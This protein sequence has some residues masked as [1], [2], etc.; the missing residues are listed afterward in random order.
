MNAPTAICCFFLVASINPAIGQPVEAWGEELGRKYAELGS[1]RATYRAVSPTA[2]EPLEGLLIE[3]R[4]T[5]ACLVRL[6]SESGQ[7][8]AVWWMPQGG[9]EKGGTYAKFGDSTFKVRGLAELVRRHQ[10]L[11]SPGEREHPPAGTPNL[12]PSIQLGVET[13]SAFLSPK[14]PGLSPA[15]SGAPPSRVEELRERQDSIELILDDGSWI[16]LD[17]GTGLLAGQGYPE[18]E[19]ER[20][21]TLESVEPLQGR[22]AFLREIP[23]IDPTKLKE[24]SP[25]ALQLANVLHSALFHQF[26]NQTHPE[27]G[28]K[29]EELV[30]SNASGLKAYW[31]AAWGHG[32]PPGFPDHVV[33]ML[34]DL[35]GQKKQFHRDWAAAKEARPDIMKDVS[36]F[37]YF[38]LRRMK[39]RDELRLKIEAESTKQPALA[40][41]Q[42]LLDGE[43]SK[44]AAGQAARG[45]ELA[46][47]MVQSQ[48][49][50]MI[51]A[52]LPKIPEEA[53]N[54]P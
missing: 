51:N 31:L 48:R 24:A 12:A 19:G 42:L 28:Q 44:L 15:F 32:V 33:R 5:G 17:R 53:L 34:R 47:L 6:Q 14:M 50:A 54:S 16:R 29:P 11:I 2:E 39:L 23:K 4:E 7:G 20:T 21:L 43:L 18:D 13:I 52:I 27:R 22:N 25:E 36:F 10:E 1:F 38:Q 30:T 37:N 46:K 26:V 8:G 3:D 41:L 45:R 9:G 35:E 40:H 49:E